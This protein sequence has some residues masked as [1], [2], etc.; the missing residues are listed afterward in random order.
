MSLTQN[1]YENM[2]WRILKNRSGYSDEEISELGN[3]KAA[4]NLAKIS[5]I[6]HWIKVEIVKS[7]RCTIGWKEGD[8]LYFDFMG[9][10]ITRKSPK[11]ICP[12]ALASLSPVLYSIMDRIGRGA[13]PQDL[14]ID[15][16][17]CTDP[18]FE[19]G[20]M[21]N[22]VM[23]IT[24]ERMPFLDLN[25]YMT[26]LAPYLFF[27]S[28]KAR[29][30]N[31]GGIPDRNE[32]SRNFQDNSTCKHS[33][34]NSDMEVLKSLKEYPLTEKER[35]VFVQSPR[36]VRKI[37]GIEKLKNV[38]IVVEIVDSTA[39]IAGHSAG[40]KIYFDSMG[41][42]LSDELDKPVCVRLINKIWNRLV[43]LMDRIAEESDEA[44]GDETFPGEI[45]EAGITCYG[46][47]FPYG[48]CGQILMKS[49]I[50]RI[51]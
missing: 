49:Y 39:C 18:G 23:R 7:N 44:I 27:Y 36:R 50:E 28:R 46:A 9:M 2:F 12:H 34:L 14:Q 17:S 47:D 37:S 10:L 1:I 8:T 5:N 3:V 29:G 15:H 16:I 25:F 42:L 31:P 24:F 35:E 38:R 26:S 20:G 33:A 41:R 19:N 51:H 40:E 21:G 43:M 45:V 22:N 32:K 11:L 13:D 6:F 48:D 4:R 30:S